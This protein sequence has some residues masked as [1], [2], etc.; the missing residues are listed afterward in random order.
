M[1]F[2]ISVSIG[3]VDI[4]ALPQVLIRQPIGMVP[5]RVNGVN[6]GSY[7]RAHQEGQTLLLAP[8]LTPFTL[9]GTIP[10]VWRTKT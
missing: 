8:K 2:S 1:R 9:P 6:F 4:A 7:F 5:G 10:I 3:I